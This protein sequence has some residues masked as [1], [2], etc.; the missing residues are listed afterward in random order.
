MENDS[1][2]MM[3][4]IAYDVNVL[5]LQRKFSVMDT[6]HSGRTQNGEMYRDVIGTFY[7]Y[8]ITI[9]ERFG[10]K[11]A[12]EAF[13]KA[14][15]SPTVSHICQFPYGQTTLTQ[16]MYVT[17]GE[18]ALLRTGGGKNHWGEITVNFIAMAP[19]VTP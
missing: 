10:D 17:G 12:L 7:N 4:G 18:Q 9:G 5:S 13:W 8:S 6:E 19:E 11:A 3:D 2:F 16:K 15:S 1:V 14:I